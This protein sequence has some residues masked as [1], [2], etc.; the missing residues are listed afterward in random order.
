MVLP[1]LKMKSLEHSSGLF[2]TVKAI[3]GELQTLLVDSKSLVMTEHL[4]RSG[5]TPKR[6]QLP[7][8]KKVNNRI[9]KTQPLYIIPS[10]LNLVHNA[11]PNIRKMF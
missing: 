1:V 8:H 9:H 3:Q 11:T 10:K 7:I 5:F 2:H 6:W 4:R